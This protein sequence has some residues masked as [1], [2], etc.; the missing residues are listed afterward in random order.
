MASVNRDKYQHTV[1]DDGIDVPAWVKHE[2][3]F[4]LDSVNQER[5]KRSLPP[6]T[7][8]DIKKGESVGDPNYG[9]RLADYCAGLCK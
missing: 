6:I 8:K 9:K 1:N 7:E 4:M 2:R 3:V 5:A